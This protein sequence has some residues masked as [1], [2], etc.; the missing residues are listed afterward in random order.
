MKRFSEFMSEAKDPGEY[1]QEGSML[2]TQLKQIDSAVDKLMGM[3]QDDD[4]L[5]EWVQSKMTKATDY[6]RTVRDYLEAE[7][8]DMD[9][10]YVSHAQRK[11][12]WANRA[13]GGKGH[14]NNKKKKKK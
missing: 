13:D 10:E 3:I 9:E 6:I 4:N 14:P 8:D 11:A 5:P 7:G 2:K 1:D 12:V